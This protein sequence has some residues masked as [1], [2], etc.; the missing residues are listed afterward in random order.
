MSAR[1]VERPLVSIPGASDA[2]GRCVGAQAR[3]SRGLKKK[4]TKKN[5][6]LGC[7]SRSQK[8]TSQ[9][10][11]RRRE[12]RGWNPLASDHDHG[13][14]RSRATH[15]LQKFPLHPQLPRGHF[16]CLLAFGLAGGVRIGDVDPQLA[17]LLRTCGNN[18]KM[19]FQ[20]FPGARKQKQNQSNK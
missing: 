10:E 15:F 4:Q 1:G 11:L 19:S 20:T 2:S 16:L 8:N 5:A 17:F 7:A 18:T 3:E 6:H 13:R 14:W 9:P 12:E